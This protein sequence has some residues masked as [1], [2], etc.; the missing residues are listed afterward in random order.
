MS[1]EV[2]TQIIQEQKMHPCY[3]KKKKDTVQIILLGDCNT[4]NHIYNVI[5]Q[6]KMPHCSLCYLVR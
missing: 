3:L 6:W 1:T 5:K 4:S 2:L